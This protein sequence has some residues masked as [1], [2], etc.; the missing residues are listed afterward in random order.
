M[1][2]ILNRLSKK[3]GLSIEKVSLLMDDILQV[4]GYETDYFFCAGC[5]AFGG[6]DMPDNVWICSECE[7]GMCDNC[8][9]ERN[10][11]CKCGEI[12]TNDNKVD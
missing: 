1:E 5:L 10:R 4:I 7:R 9:N 11:I 6:C 8:L 12:L 2:K 3:H